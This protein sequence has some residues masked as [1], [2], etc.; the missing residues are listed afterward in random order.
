MQPDAN[1]IVHEVLSWVGSCN[2]CPWLSD[3][4]ADHQVAGAAPHPAARVEYDRRA[5]G[6]NRGGGG[7]YRARGG[8]DFG[9]AA[10]YSKIAIRATICEAPWPRGVFGVEIGQ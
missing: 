5:A 6:K 4:P 8:A 9:I 1:L 7:R 3:R 2:H 10:I